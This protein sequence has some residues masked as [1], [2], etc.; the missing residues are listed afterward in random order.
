MTSSTDECDESNIKQALT[1]LIKQ[2]VNDGENKMVV[3][4]LLDIHGQL[5]TNI[6]NQAKELSVAI[7]NIIAYIEKYGY[8]TFKLT[9]VKHTMYKK[10]DFGQL[11]VREALEAHFGVVT[12]IRHHSIV[13]DDTVR[14]KT[15]YCM[16]NSFLGAI[17][18]T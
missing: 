4:N 2:T 9:E 3:N 8:V 5:I 16:S 11:Q 15:M 10:G 7:A 17:V 14:V 1:T 13:N 12:E 6:R 18:I